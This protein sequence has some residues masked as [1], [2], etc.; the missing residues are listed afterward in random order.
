MDITKNS[1]KD[2]SKDINKDS[3][4]NSC[5]PSSS[6]EGQE[7]AL[8]LV[9]VVTLANI[10][11]EDAQRPTQALRQVSPLGVVLRGEVA[12]SK[13]G[14]AIFVPV[15]SYSKFFPTVVSDPNCTRNEN[16]TYSIT[17]KKKKP[18]F[19]SPLLFPGTRNIYYRD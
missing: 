4:S 17:L 14:T 2:S 11:V 13:S 8:L 19:V 6:V 5:F 9:I 12:G 15:V 18:S 1:S 3:S 16:I 7:G 10:L